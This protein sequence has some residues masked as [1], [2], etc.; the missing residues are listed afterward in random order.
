MYTTAPLRCSR[1]IRGLDRD[2]TVRL[3]D[4]VSMA[5]V[6]SVGVCLMS[7]WPHAMSYLRP[8]SDV[9]LVKPV[10]ACFV[11]VM[12]RVRPRSVADMEPC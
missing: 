9:D 1:S 6:I 5:C 12:E 4:A 11:A 10:I 8:S 2:L 7:I 3:A